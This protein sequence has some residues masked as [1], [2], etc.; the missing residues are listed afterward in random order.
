MAPKCHCRDNR[1]GTG[2][3]RRPDSNHFLNFGVPIRSFMSRSIPDIQKEFIFKT[4]RSGGKGGQNVNK[5]ESRVEARW[6]I[7][8]SRLVTEEERALLQRKLASRMTADGFISVIASDSRSQLE[9]KQHAARRLA[10]LIE[11]ALII[12]LKRKKTSIPKAVKEK[13]L[14]DKRLSSEKKANRRRPI[15]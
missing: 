10:T 12:P 3:P 11:K 2:E 13:R 14:S 6:E 5:V 7:G 4:S 9:N 8:V 1:S 15:E